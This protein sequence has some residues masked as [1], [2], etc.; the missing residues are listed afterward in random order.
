MANSI[1]SYT[2]RVDPS[3]LQS[4]AQELGKYVSTMRRLFESVASSVNGLANYWEGEASDEY[5]K[6]YER[7][8][9]EIEEM[10]NRLG[11]HSTDLNSI[12]AVY[13][14][15]ESSNEDI[16]QDLSSDVIV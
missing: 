13:T 3:V 6:R 14:G 9:P 1:G 11:E 15:V 2:L 8:K 10:L 4:Q 16:A 5:R 12:A 7:L